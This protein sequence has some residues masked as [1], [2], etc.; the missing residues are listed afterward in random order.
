MKNRLFR[1]APE[2]STMAVTAMVVALM[3]VH[4]Q[5]SVNHDVGTARD[6]T[7]TA[8]GVSHVSGT[9]SASNAGVIRIDFDPYG[10]RHPVQ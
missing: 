1:L 5:R 9:R 3:T 10:F 7:V 4:A 2:G 6:A 8:H